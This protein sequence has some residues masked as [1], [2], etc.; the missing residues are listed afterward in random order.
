MVIALCAN[1]NRI[2]NSYLATREW[3]IFGR[4]VTYKK[5]YNV[6]IYLFIGH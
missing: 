1:R 3:K 2:C 4:A 5:G 6:Y